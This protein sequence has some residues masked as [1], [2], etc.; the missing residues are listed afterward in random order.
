V[1]LGNPNSLGQRRA[2]YA[3]AVTVVSG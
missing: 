1:E 3:V 2:Y